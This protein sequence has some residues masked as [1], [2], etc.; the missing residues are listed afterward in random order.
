MVPDWKTNGKIRTQADSFRDAARGFFHT[1]KTE[2]NMRI[3]LTAAVY[4]L[5]FSPFLGV[6]RG[7]YGILL[8]TVALVIAA[9]AFNTAI[10]ILCD[11]AQKSYNP[12][13]GKT[14]DI[15]AGAVLV[16]AVFAAFVGITILWRPKALWALIITIVT[17]PLYLVLF[18]LSLVSAFMFIFKGSFRHTG[19]AHKINKR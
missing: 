14:K 13:I 2:R 3:H 17:N 9:E 12:L 8:L 4:V 18:I 6:T 1:V 10:E 11:Y 15:A 19:K 16:C 7:E 5:F